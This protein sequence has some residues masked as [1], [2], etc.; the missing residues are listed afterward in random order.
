MT[1]TDS[2]TT[3]GRRLQGGRRKGGQELVQ[4]LADV[5]QELRGGILM[6]N[7]ALRKQ[8]DSGIDVRRNYHLPQLHA[9]E[10]VGKPGLRRAGDR[11]VVRFERPGVFQPGVAKN[12][13]V[14]AAAKF[15]GWHAVDSFG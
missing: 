8:E 1:D 5:A 10:G 15:E 6:N 9:T 2:H 13:A 14:A 3:L 7:P 4:Q 12:E 11:Q